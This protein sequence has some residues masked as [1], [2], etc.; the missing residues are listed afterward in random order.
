MEDNVSLTWKIVA[1]LCFVIVLLF[2]MT[3]SY[4]DELMEQEIYCDNLKN[5][6][7]PDYR[8]IKEECK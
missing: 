2:A 4:E 6:S 5:G 7:H 3:E 1:V 8:G